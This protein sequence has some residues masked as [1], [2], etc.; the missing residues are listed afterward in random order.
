VDGALYQHATFMHCD[1]YHT[2]TAA[3]ITSVCTL[4]FA[5]TPAGE[6]I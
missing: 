5:M 1:L 2:A 3:E 4:C 6:A